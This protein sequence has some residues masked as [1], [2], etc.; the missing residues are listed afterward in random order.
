M[1][2][3]KWGPLLGIVKRKD[4]SEK[5]KGRDGFPFPLLIFIICQVKHVTQLICFPNLLS[6]PFSKL[7]FNGNLIVLFFMIAGF[8]SL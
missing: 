6:L 3:G 1:N 4:S 8:M 2:K 7:A 5:I